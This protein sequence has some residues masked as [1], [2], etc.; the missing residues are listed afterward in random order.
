[1]SRNTQ[2]PPYIQQVF[3]YGAVTPYGHTFQHV[4]LACT[5]T[6]SAVLQPRRCRNSAGLGSCAFARHYLRNHCYFLFL[7]VLRCFSSPGSPGAWRRTC[8]R[9]VGCPIRKSVL[10]R[11]FA[12]GHGLSQLVTSFF[13]SES[14]GILHVPFSPFRFSLPMKHRESPFSRCPQAAAAFAA[15]DLRPAACARPPV[16]LDSCC[17]L[18]CSFCCRCSCVLTLHRFPDEFVWAGTRLRFQYVNVLFLSRV[19]NNGFEPLTPCLQSR[20]SSQLS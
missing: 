5:D 15:Y 11:V 6:L 7:R 14:Q 2:V 13:A 4:P 20:C 19:E 9:Q 10:M 16:A 3:G 17:C 8:Q 1:M 12:P 18:I